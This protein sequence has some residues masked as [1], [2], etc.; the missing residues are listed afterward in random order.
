MAHVCIYLLCAKTDGRTSTCV[1][2][3]LLLQEVNTDVSFRVC[4]NKMVSVTTCSSPI[5]HISFGA[6]LKFQ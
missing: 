4:V 1:L 5:S 3:S 6:S 2:L